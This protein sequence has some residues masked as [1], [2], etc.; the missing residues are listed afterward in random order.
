MR[1]VNPFPYISGHVRRYLLDHPDVIEAL[2]SGRIGTDPVP[3]PLRD[4][5]VR[6]AVTGQSGSTPRRRQLIVQV[7]PWLPADPETTDATYDPAEIVWDVA[8]VI[9]QVGAQARNVTIDEHTAWSAEWIE[10]PTELFDDERGI[11]AAL[12]F[13]PVTFLVTVSHR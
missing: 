3:S 2:G 10:G 6:V 9:G 7:T 1:R 13:T 12:L 8:T 4:I 11:D 5:Y